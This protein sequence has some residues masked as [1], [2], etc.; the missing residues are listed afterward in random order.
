MAAASKR[1]NSLSCPCTTFHL[2]YN[3]GTER[4][5][6]R[7]GMNRK[8]RCGVGVLVVAMEGERVKEGSWWRVGGGL[9]SHR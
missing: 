4:E 6:V 5:I 7:D 2:P 3:N 9:Q 1:A 8:W